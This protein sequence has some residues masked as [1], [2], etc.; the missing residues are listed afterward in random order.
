MG[1]DRVFYGRCFVCGQV[2]D[3]SNSSLLSR[4]YANQVCSNCF[5]SNKTVVLGIPEDSRI[6]SGLLR[7]ST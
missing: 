2:L 5:C 3:D 7:R 1:K 4:A 6:D